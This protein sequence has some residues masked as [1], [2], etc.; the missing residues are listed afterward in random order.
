MEEDEPQRQGSLLMERG[1]PEG[2]EPILTESSPPS[3]KEMELSD[4]SPVQQQGHQDTVDEAPE[5]DSAA[6]AAKQRALAEQ[7]S[8]LTDKDKESIISPSTSITPETVLKEDP[9]NGSKIRSHLI[10]S[11]SQVNKLDQRQETAKSGLD[12]GIESKPTSDSVLEYE[13]GLKTYFETSSQSHEE[14][15]LQ[16][17][18]YYEL[19]TV[20]ETRLSEQNLEEFNVESSHQKIGAS[21]TSSVETLSEQRNVSLNITAGSLA[22]QTM[23]GGKSQPFSVEGHTPTFPPSMSI[24]PTTT[25]SPE[26]IP[27]KAETSLPS[28]R[29]SSTFEHSSSLSEMMDLAGALPKLSLE[30][31]EVDHMR[32]KSVPA[33]VSALVGSSFV[34]LALGEQTQRV[35]G[36]DS[37]LDDLGYCVF[38]EYSGPMP[39]PADVSSPGDSPHQHFPSIEGESEE[40]LRPAE[41]KTTQQA[42]HKQTIPEMSQKT[43]TGRKDVLGSPM[44]SMM[45]ERAVTMGMKPDRLR[46]PMSSSKDRLA[47]FHLESGLSC[48]ITIHAIPEVDVEKDP[49]R[50]ASPIPPDT[51]FTFTSTENGSKIP[52]TPTTPKSPNGA[53]PGPQA[54]EMKSNVEAEKDLEP[55]I[56]DNEQKELLKCDQKRE[57]H[58][59]VTGKTIPSALSETSKE[60]IEKGHVKVQSDYQESDQLDTTKVMKHV[61]I[62]TPFKEKSNKVQLQEFTLEKGSTKPPMSFPIIIIPQAQ[63]DKEAAEDYDIEIAEEP[64]EIM[65]EAEGS[66]LQ[67]EGGL[68]KEVTNEELRLTEGVRLAVNESKSAEEESHHSAQMGDEGGPATDS[69]HL[70]FCSDHDL[71]QPAIEGGGDQDVGKDKIAEVGSDEV[72]AENVAEEEEREERTGGMEAFEVGE[73]ICDVL[74]QS[75]QTAQDGTSMPDTDSGWMDSQGTTAT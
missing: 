15:A 56:T 26:D 39:S 27:A 65:E 36:G 3:V 19:S 61:T 29:H 51:S 63:V 44:K 52:L 1:N 54:T 50:E 30:R 4:S 71:P 49:S 9:E 34:K 48:N 57:D 5:G 22:D 75:S 53:F 66:V 69:S 33:N 32:R 17:Q 18:S 20:M 73:E 64:Q 14:E 67:E 62:D 10:S 13:S 72:G 70:S 16:T 68:V 7:C 12:T 2:G 58:M 6:V 42:D 46:I 38:N 25:D 41:V 74:S 55:E 31:M 24:T 8:H 28:T 59:L 43:A 21:G 11:L 37:Q 35:V 40:E 23:K 47:E 60:N 45:L